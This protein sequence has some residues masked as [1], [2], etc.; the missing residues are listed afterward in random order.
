VKLVYAVKIYVD[1][2]DQELKPGMPV[3]AY[4]PLEPENQDHASNLDK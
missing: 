4:I 2:P 1:N 3:D